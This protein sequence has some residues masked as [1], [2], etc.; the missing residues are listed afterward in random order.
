VN[1]ADWAIAVVVLISVLQAASSGFFQEAFGI[2]GLVLGY[3]VAAWQYHRLAAWFAPNLKEAWVGDLLAFM[4][5]FLGIMLLAGVTGRIARWA[6]KEAGLSVIDRVLGGLLG[7][8]RGCLLVAIILTSVA[9]FNPVSR[10]LDGSELA[11]YFLVVGRVAIWV[12]PRDLRNRFY[13]GLDLLRK[14]APSQVTPAG[15]AGGAV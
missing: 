4:I 14:Q 6:V 9:A 1:G 10:W 8:V 5:I 12:A 7:L 11:P 3:L 2:A 15:G 13:Q